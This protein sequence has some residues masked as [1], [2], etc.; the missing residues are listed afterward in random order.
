MRLCVENQRIKGRLLICGTSVHFCRNKRM[1]FRSWTKRNYIVLLGSLLLCH[2][3]P[4]GI[5][6]LEILI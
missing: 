4:Q 3:F 2:V 5:R 6:E 1:S